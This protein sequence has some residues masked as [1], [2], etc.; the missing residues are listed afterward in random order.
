MDLMSKKADAFRFSK[1][2]YK[3]IR[4]KIKQTSGDAVG[5]SIVKSDNS[6]AKSI[7]DL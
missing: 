6:G 2:D 1:D 5:K 4:N 7:F 3:V